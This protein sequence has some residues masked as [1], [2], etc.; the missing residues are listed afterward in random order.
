MSGY[1]ARSW[2]L[3]HP[4]DSMNT[5][6]GQ[7]VSDVEDA[8]DLTFADLQRD[9]AQAGRASESVTEV[10]QREGRTVD[11]RQYCSPV[12]DQGLLESCV[13]FA[14]AALVE[15]LQ[16]RTERPA[17]VCSPRFIWYLARTYELNGALNVG[18]QIRNGLR[19][20]THVGCSPEDLDP[21]PPVAFMPPPPPGQVHHIEAL[22]DAA[23]GRKPSQPA[24]AAASHAMLDA[25][26][27]LRSLREFKACLDLGYGFVM[28]CPIFAS[29]MDSA[30]RHGRMAMPQPGEEPVA[31]HTLF[32]CGYHDDGTTEG[33]GY[34]VCKGS[35]GRRRGQT[36]YFRVPYAYA[37][38]KPWRLDAWTAIRLTT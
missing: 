35:Q 11:L 31:S 24:I 17:D 21:Y 33:G 14:L 8:R 29:G 6:W 9:L 7:H 34:L 16:R 19:V 12:R 38:A 5:G 15:F 32:V 37:D 23:A 26:Y 30:L 3:Q 25:Y 13:G 22:L 2:T 20:L 10:E 28:S 27:R 4:G 36:G 1:R 18:A